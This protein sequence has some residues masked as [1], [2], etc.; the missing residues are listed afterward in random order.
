MHFHVVEVGFDAADVS[1]SAIDV[2]VMARDAIVG[3]VGAD[4]VAVEVD[5]GGAEVPVGAVG[6][7]VTD[8]FSGVFGLSV[9][10]RSA[11]ADS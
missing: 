3:M 9:K 8:P 2:G 10:G 4:D 6:A 11:A 5:F 7:D 1:F